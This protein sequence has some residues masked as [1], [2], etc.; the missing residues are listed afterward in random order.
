MSAAIW[1]LS[2]WLLYDPATPPVQWE[3]ASRQECMDKAALWHE[4][5]LQWRARTEHGGP[6]LV[7]PIVS[8]C[9]PARET[10]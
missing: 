8:R 2:V 6:K 1:V 10:S 5:A 3:V 7:Q 9:E 4:A